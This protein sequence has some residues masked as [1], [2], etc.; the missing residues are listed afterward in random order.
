[1]TTCVV[2]DNTTNELVNIIIASPTDVPP[3]NCRLLELPEN[4][5]W[6]NSA[7][8]I[9]PMTHYWN[10]S[11]IVLIPDNYYRINDEIFPVEEEN[12]N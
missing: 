3:L 2:I 10:G 4:Y 12:G 5:Y 9:I 6:S 7:K 8:Q 1:M 11:E